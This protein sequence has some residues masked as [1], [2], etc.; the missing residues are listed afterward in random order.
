ME[1]LVDPARFRDHATVMSERRRL[2]VRVEC[3][4]DGFTLFEGGQP[5]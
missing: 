1:L 3:D 5:K 4:E 2:A